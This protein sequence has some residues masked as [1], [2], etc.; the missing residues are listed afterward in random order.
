MP[1]PMGTH[2]S[3]D[4][5]LLRSFVLIAEENSFT[6]AA[7]RVGR[8]QSAVSL[9]V[10]RLESLVGHRLIER[11]KGTGV[12]LTAQGNYLLDRAR[13]LLSLNDEILS[14]VG[15]GARPQDGS[16]AGGSRAADLPSIVVL[17][18]QNLSDEP[19]DILAAGVVDGIVAGL[20]RISWLV[21][22]ARGSIIGYRDRTIDV[23]QIGRELNVR[24]VLQ[25]SVRQAGARVRIT[26]QLLEAET[27]KHLWAKD[28]DGVLEDVFDLQDQVADQIVGVV[29]PSLRRFETERSRRRP[30]DSLDAFSLYLRAFPHVAAQ[31]PEEASKAL[32]LL[33]HAL[34]L[35]PD[36][37]PA[38]ALL[39]WG[40]EL[41][42][43]RGGLKKEDRKAALLHARTAI[44]ADTDDGTAVAIA[45]FVMALLT[46]NGDAGLSTI[47]RGLSMNPSS[48]KVRYLCAQANAMA[49]K[50]R[51]AMSLA[52]QA[53]SFSPTDGFAF[54]AHMALGET[55]L[56]EERFKDAASCFA[57]A[58][59]AKPNFSSA[60][61]FQ[62][63][64]LAQAGR[65][66]Q[67]SNCLARGFRTRA[68]V[69]PA[70]ILRA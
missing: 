9:Q 19:R 35:D 21:V 13:E 16:P 25:G 48:A 22:M 65:H 47:E 8:T 1:D 51:Y 43:V 4:I 5:D 40:H 41:C 36:Y 12:R 49:G 18:F 39:A 68:R 45:G 53:L 31:M 69:P 70:R 30:T 52:D 44:A 28:Y 63:I 60:Y 26:V 54:Q 62:A 42:F 14:S 64:A 61:I 33:Q 57:R 50:R 59:Q 10:Q 58:A 55:A 3:L 66:G 11:G 67:A 17:P 46:K 2:P 29:E 20:S 56:Q 37:A 34:K 15:S 32:P 6:R 27:R 38:H 7:E 23:R 24:Y